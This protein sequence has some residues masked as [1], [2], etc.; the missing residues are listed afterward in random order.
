MDDPAWIPDFG[1]R[2]FNPAAGASAIGARGLLIA[3][4]VNLADPDPAAAR[5]IAGF[6]RES[7]G[8]VEA[9]GESGNPDGTGMGRGGQPGTPGGGPSG[10]ARESGIT[11]SLPRPAGAAGS[12]SVTPGLF[13]ACKAMGWGI[14]SRGCSQVSTNL[15]DYR[16]TPPHAVYEACVRLAAE[17]GTRVTGSEIVGLIPLDALLAAGKH[18][19]GGEGTFRDSAEES[20]CIRG[21]IR[22]LGLDDWYP[23]GPDLKIRERRLSGRISQ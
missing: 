21:A 17:T 9:I 3:Y 11:A 4:N 16:I 22:G 20:A 5:R 19:A 10:E 15:T 7:G 23:F 12:P 8:R 18:F 6:I 1:P 2:R 13:R 14:A